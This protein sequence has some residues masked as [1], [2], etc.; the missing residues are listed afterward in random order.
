MRCDHNWDIVNQMQALLQT[1]ARCLDTPCGAQMAA[2]EASGMMVA[3]MLWQQGV[4]REVSTWEL[5]VEGAMREMERRVAEEESDIQLVYI[6]NIKI[7]GNSKE[8][9]QPSNH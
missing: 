6:C 9:F 3:A 5:E 1:G 4:M 2:Q 8:M 7:K